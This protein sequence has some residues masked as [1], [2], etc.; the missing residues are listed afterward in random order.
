MASKF[1]IECMHA[2]RPFASG[3][4]CARFGRERHLVRGDEVYPGARSAYAERAPVGLIDRI[5]RRTD[6]C[7]PG[8]AHYKHHAA[9]PK[10]SS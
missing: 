2:A 6:K 10:I 9:P 8:G 7:G 1:C 4:L 3:L 5:A